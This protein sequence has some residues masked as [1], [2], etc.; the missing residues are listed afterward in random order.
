MID[1]D[2]MLS[3]EKAAK[4]KVFKI[5]LDKGW[6]FLVIPSCVEEK[7]PSLPNLAQRA[8][9]ASSSVANQSNELEVAMTIAS[10]ADFSSSS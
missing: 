6:T 9:N 1:G 3:Y 8:L 7:F 2:G 5:M 4:D 10:M